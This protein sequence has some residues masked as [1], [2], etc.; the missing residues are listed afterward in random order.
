MV[1]RGGLL[2][3]TKKK[4]PVNQRLTGL[5]CGERGSVTHEFTQFQYVPQCR[6]TLI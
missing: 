1:V 3:S 6:K 2:K 5:C 4:S